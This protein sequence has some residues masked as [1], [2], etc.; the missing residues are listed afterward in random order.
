MQRAIRFHSGDENRRRAGET[1]KRRIAAFSAATI[2]AIGAIVAEAVLNEREA[3]IDR[4]GAEAANL[5]AGFEERIRSALDAAP[6]LKRRMEATEP[7]L[8]LEEWKSVARDLLDKQ[9]KVFLGEA[10]AIDLI[11]SDGV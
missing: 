7:T 8:S 10:A 11:R 5:A 9:Q 6:D 3:A 4:A 1:L 2:F